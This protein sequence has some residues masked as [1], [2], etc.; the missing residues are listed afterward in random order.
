MPKYSAQL[1]NGKTITLEGE[2]QPSDNDFEQAAK[3]AGVELLPEGKTLEDY[4]GSNV[5]LKQPF[6]VAAADTAK[7]ILPDL[8]EQLGGAASLVTL[9]ARAVGEAGSMIGNKARETFGF[10]PNPDAGTEAIHTIAGLPR[11]AY[12][13]YKG[14]GDE[15]TRAIQMREHPVGTAADVVG[16]LS[17]AKGGIGVAKKIPRGA[18]EIL[19]AHGP[20]IRKAARGGVLGVAGR[21]AEN[22]GEWM[23]PTAKTAALLNV[24][25]GLA[26]PLKPQETKA[27]PGVVES[28]TFP[29][30]VTTVRERYDYLSAKPI[31]TPAEESMWRVLDN[32][33]HG[34]GATNRGVGY[35]TR[36]K[37][38][39]K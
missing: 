14:Y 7:H 26:A 35:A 19:K 32:A 2:T 17:A 31:R 20:L 21:Y 6:M 16:I 29:E 1:T 25:E 4:R 37:S 15:N 34:S 13:H 23:S 27:A 22:L 3:G 18:G 8:G 39:G 11:A 9:P 10:Q 12:E 5:Y 38:T 28:V 36:G 33:M 30:N 24:E